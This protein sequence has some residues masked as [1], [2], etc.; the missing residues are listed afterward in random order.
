LTEINFHKNSSEDVFHETHITE[1]PSFE[2]PVEEIKEAYQPIITNQEEVLTEIH[3]PENSDEEAFHETHITENSSFEHPVDEIK[4]TYQPIITNQEEILTEIHHPENSDEEVF[5][6]THITENHLFEDHVEE[7]KEIYHPASPGN[8]KIISE[9]HPATQMDEQNINP[10]TVSQPVLSIEPFQEPKAFELTFEP[11]H[12][13]DYFASQGIKFIQE[14]NPTDKFGKQLKTFT[15][16]LKT[17]K[18]LPPNPLPEDDP[19]DTNN[20]EIEMIAANS[21]EAKDVE[22]ETMAEVL[23]KQGKVDKAIEMYLKLSLLNPTKIAY[24]AAKIEHIK[25]TLL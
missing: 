22:T 6:E 14:E 5:H 7:A 4:E 19:D 20:A 1:N 17:M 24:F 8:E 18:R 12:T 13:I 11:Y 16:W 2:H 21:I 10:E 9:T 25:R 15:D 23:A 3:H